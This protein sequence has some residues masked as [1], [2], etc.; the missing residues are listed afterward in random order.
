MI[1][2]RS[3]PLYNI[4]SPQ[5]FTLRGLPSK[6]L[7]CAGNS[8]WKTVPSLSNT[9]TELSGYIT[10]KVRVVSLTTN[11]SNPFNCWLQAFTTLTRAP[12]KSAFVNLAHRVF[13]TAQS[14]ASKPLTNSYGLTVNNTVIYYN[15][16]AFIYLNVS[17]FSS[18]PACWCIFSMVLID[19]WLNFFAFLFSG[20]CCF[21]K[22]CIASCYCSGS[23]PLRAF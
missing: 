22:A 4:L 17:Y 7:N 13:Y 9:L 18:S 2:V 8:N 23:W 21:D 16:N 11:P 3:D 20:L 1:L 14:W 15:H 12:E 19:V 6:S 10:T 5:M